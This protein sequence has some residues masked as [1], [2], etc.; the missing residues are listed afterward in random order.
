MGT[1]VVPADLL[2]RSRF[3][4]SPLAETVAALTV[5]SA[6]D[7]PGVPWQRAFRA[8]HQEAYAEMIDGD[9]VR[10]ALS[11]WLWRPRRGSVP[12][13]MGDFLTPPPVGPGAP[14]D[15]ELAQLDAWDDGRIRAE[16][17]TMRPGVPLPAVLERGGLRRATGEILTW[18]W[19]ATVAADWPR[20]RR[21]LEADIVSRTARLATQGWAGVVPTLGRRMEWRGGGHLQINAYDLP[22]RDLSDARELSFVPVHGHGQW[23]AW[24]LP[25]RFAIVYPVTGAQAGADGPAADGLS[26]LVG[27][28][29]AR[30]L[31]LLDEPRST[32]Q[33]AAITGLP[34]GAVGNHLRVLLDAG[35]VVRRRSGREV[36]YW[37]TSLGDALVAAGFAE[38]P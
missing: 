21:V 26:R 3:Q 8:A 12:G 16:I 9:P 4:V 10:A 13:W 30:V 11:G 28:N 29:R 37:R 15:A 17:R 32:T 6:P 25:E 23:V 27:P 22:T 19:T 20:R 35:A 1:W 5:L 36:L 14:F 2:A 34:V 33:L 24:D 38:R 7:P 18:V 31:V